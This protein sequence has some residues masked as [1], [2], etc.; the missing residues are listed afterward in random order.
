MP[1]VIS[2]DPVF[3]RPG[4]PQTPGPLDKGGGKGQKHEHINPLPTIE[5]SL[6]KQ[7]SLYK[8]LAPSVIG[9]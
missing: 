9:W 7:K 1:A 3:P 2:P 5:N 8:V 4:G 6:K